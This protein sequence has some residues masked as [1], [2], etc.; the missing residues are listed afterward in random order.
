MSFL[1]QGNTQND[2]KISSSHISWPRNGLYFQSRKEEKDAQ[3]FNNYISNMYNVLGT[4]NK[5][6]K[7]I[8]ISSL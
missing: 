8:K 6:V 7:Q 2:K 5:L 1:S 3:L 4:R